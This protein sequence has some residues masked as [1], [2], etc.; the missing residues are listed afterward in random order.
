M[1]SFLFQPAELVLEALWLGFRPIPVLIRGSADCR[2]PHQPAPSGSGWLNQLNQLTAAVT[3]VISI[4][5]PT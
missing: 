3:I 5:L 2:E 4:N 1:L